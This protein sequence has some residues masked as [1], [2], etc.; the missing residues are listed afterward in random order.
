MTAKGLGRE[1][2]IRDAV[3]FGLISKQDFHAVNT[4]P[5]PVPGP[6][7]PDKSIPDLKQKKKKK[8]RGFWENGGRLYHR[9]CSHG[10]AS[11]PAG[12]SPG[13]P[14]E[15]A[16][17]R[18]ACRAASRRLRSGAARPRAPRPGHPG[19]DRDVHG[20]G[21]GGRRAKRDAGEAAALN[22]G[23]VGHPGETAG[24]VYHLPWVAG[25]RKGWYC[26]LLAGSEP[27]V[28]Y[29]ALGDAQKRGA[30]QARNVITKDMI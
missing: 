9:P 26:V 30:T 6:S 13:S 11:S 25:A 7:V 22:P 2:G 3:L 8:K 4:R 21:W 23:A 15:D 16:R 18:I 17:L 19:R 12:S 5:A 20:G 28:I 1:E 10:R 27:S 29:R 14:Q 24:K